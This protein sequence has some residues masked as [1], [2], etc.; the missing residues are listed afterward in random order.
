M[1]Y[2]VIKSKHVCV[3]WFWLKRC[4]RLPCM[5]CIKSVIWLNIKQS[6]GTL[7]PNAQTM[8]ENLYE[9]EGLLGRMH[10]ASISLQTVLWTVVILFGIWK[11][12]NFTN[13]L[14]WIWYHYHSGIWLPILALRQPYLFRLFRTS[15]ACFS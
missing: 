12:S 7:L 10:N 15:P 5:P 4:S 8:S 3:K 1:N 14:F 2:I 6:S 11:C 9:N 13:L